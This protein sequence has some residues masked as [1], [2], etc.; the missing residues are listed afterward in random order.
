MTHAVNRRLSVDGATISDARSVRADTAAALHLR[1]AW[2]A[3]RLYALAVSK[4]IRANS[5]KA[6][7]GTRPMGVKVRMTDGGVPALISWV[8]ISLRPRLG[9]H[10]ATMTTLNRPIFGA[11]FYGQ[12][13]WFFSPGI[14]SLARELRSLGIDSTT[15]AYGQVQAAI[16]ELDRRSS[17][18][19]VNLLYGYSLG[20]TSVTYIQTVRQVSLCFAIAASKLG[21]NHPINKR[22]TAR[23]VL[24]RAP[25]FLSSAG[26]GLGFDEVNDIV[27]PHLMMS[28]AKPVLNSAVAEALALQRAPIVHTVQWLQ[29]SLN[30]LIK[31]GLTTDGILGPRTIGAIKTF[32][33]AHGLVVDGW[34]GRATIG[35]I[36]RL[37]REV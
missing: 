22:N 30:T 6:A 2:S 19:F 14:D 12:G 32:Q 17:R 18:G 28:F 10:S 37:L 4:G 29:Q 7:V 13:G 23:A 36:E 24:W 15:Y 27:R 1:R 8:S 26:G 35:M 20:V 16:T 3:R 34:A 11:C 5:V 9:Q 25:G 31:A 21:Q 33:Q